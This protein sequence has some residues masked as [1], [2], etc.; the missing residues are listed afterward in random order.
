MMGVDHFTNSFVPPMYSTTIYR[1]FA[2]EE[3]FF[4]FWVKTAAYDCVIKRFY[5]FITLIS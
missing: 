1:I 2:D 3:Q 4:L 5:V